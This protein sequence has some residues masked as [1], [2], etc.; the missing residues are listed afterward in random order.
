M[1][2]L[3]PLR[4]ISRVESLSRRAA[5]STKRLPSGFEA[6]EDKER[7]YVQYRLTGYTRASQRCP[8]N[9]RRFQEK[10][11]PQ[12][13]SQST[14]SSSSLFV[15]RSTVQSILDSASQSTL[16]SALQSVLQSGG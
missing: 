3:E 8:V 10:S 14:S 5:S 11:S 9:I 13:A 4:T 12:S 16:K 15:P 6:T 7:Q 1:P 2:T